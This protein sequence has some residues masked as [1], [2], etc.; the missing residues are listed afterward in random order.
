MSSEEEKAQQ[1][2]KYVIGSLFVV[3]I[4]S[5]CVI[6]VLVNDDDLHEDSLISTFDSIDTSP[7]SS[8]SDLAI[9]PEHSYSGRINRVRSKKSEP[10]VKSPPKHNKAAPKKT[11]PKK[12]EDGP[13]LIDQKGSLHVQL[14]L[15][16]RTHRRIERM[17]RLKKFTVR[18]EPVS[19]IDPAFHVRRT[20]VDPETLSATFES[21]KAVTW[22]VIIGGIRAGL[23]RVEPNKR[24]HFVFDTDNPSDY[25]RLG[26]ILV[27]DAVEE[28]VQGA[29]ILWISTRS[30]DPVHEAVLVG[31][32]DV[33]G[34]LPVLDSQSGVF[35]ARKGDVPPILCKPNPG[36]ARR[37][38][39]MGGNIVVAKLEDQGLTELLGKIISDRTGRGIE[40]AF[41]EVLGGSNVF[42]R[43][44]KRQ[45]SLLSYR[46][47]A[48][49]GKISK[50]PI[51]NGVST[52]S[53]AGGS[54]R[55]RGVRPGSNVVVVRHPSLAS[56][57]PRRLNVKKSDNKGLSFT[58]KAGSYAKG[59]VKVLG[60]G[61]SQAGTYVVGT[62]NKAV[63][64][65]RVA[66]D[67]SYESR[68]HSQW[69]FVIGPALKPYS[70][71]FFELKN[72]VAPE[73]N[74]ES[75]CDFEVLTR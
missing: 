54:F 63:Y 68:G 40:G 66:R 42:A 5:L 10:R 23:V 2:S 48:R 7:E 67:G 56:P 39:M 62:H 51:E 4:L 64:R 35:L 60:A 19:G 69:Q 70:T 20:V 37:Q 61:R 32:T 58:M 41:I 24:A 15:D 12:E 21:V 18:I 9:I 26:M 14:F 29:E 65:Q 6:G 34:M 71:Q 1:K 36:V 50:Y 72:V 53:R 75:R 11:S 25:V 17:K 46:R 45:G 59:R 30:K 47:G 49:S 13:L 52:Y 38:N 33:H 31:K 74:K 55:L 3:L 8:A 43:L 22:L 16:R 27:V 57:E 73:A 28:P 44:R